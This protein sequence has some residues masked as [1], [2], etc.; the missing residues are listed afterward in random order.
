MDA[1]HS[2]RERWRTHFI[3]LGEIMYFLVLW[4]NTSF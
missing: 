1:I 3:F 2:R 4:D